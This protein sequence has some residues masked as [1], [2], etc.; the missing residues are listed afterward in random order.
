MIADPGLTPDAF[1][2]AYV[3]TYIE[4]DIR[5]LVKIQDESR[6]LRFIACAAART[7]QEKNIADMAR[8]VG[9]NAHTAENWLSLL[10][11]SG[12]VIEIRP[13]SGNTIKR[14]VKRPKLYFM[15]TGLACHLSLWNSP[16]ALRMSAMAG[17][18]FET[19]VV[20]EIVKSYANA[21]LDT[22]N[23]FCWY[24]DNNGRE[25][26]LMILHD[27]KIH[28]I[29]IKKSADPGSG[30]LKHFGA[31]SALREEV[32]EGAVICLSR[33]VIPLDRQNRILPAGCL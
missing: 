29:E 7:G 12:L 17:P 4:R 24:R 23:R 1:Y 31:L 22:R 10:V 9:V 26:D 21:G 20:A 3:Q 33:E 18:M 15:D 13:Y 6:F 16:E 14:I 28:P 2:S 5:A 30:A 11:S 25:I 27:G 32:G 8:D 19:W